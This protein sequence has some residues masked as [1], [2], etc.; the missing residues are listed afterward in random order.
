MR[1]QI[2]CIAL[3]VSLS[4]YAQDAVNFSQE[5]EFYLHGASTTIGN[6]ILGKD[7]REPFDQVD[8]S[9]DFLDMKYIDVDGYANTYSSS[10]AYLQLDA[11][12][13]IIYAVLY[14]SGTYKGE[15][16][17]KYTNK[18]RIYYKLLEERQHDV[19]DIKFKVPG[20]G[21]KNVKG[22]LIYDGQDARSRRIKSRAP[23]A[24]MADVTEYIRGQKSGYITVANV[25]ATQGEVDGGSAA[26]WLL[27]VVYKDAHEPLRYVVTHQGFTMVDKK[28]LEI[29]F[30]SFQIPKFMKFQA[31]VTVGAIDGDRS[32]EGDKASLY[33]AQKQ[34]FLSMKT[35]GRPSDNFFNSSITTF[36][37]ENKLRIPNSSNTLGFDV[38]QFSIPTASINSGAKVQYTTEADD[39]FVFF[40]AFQTDVDEQ[41]YKE[42][43]YSTQLATN[44]I[45]TN[46]NSNDMDLAKKKESLVKAGNTKSVTTRTRISSQKKVISRSNEK[47]LR[48][49]IRNPSVRIEKVPSGYYIISNVFSDVSNAE[50]WMTKLKSRG[51]NPERFYRPEKNLH[52]VFLDTGFNASEL[53][54]KVKQLRTRRGLRDTWML[55]VNLN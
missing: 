27:Y 18:D 49:I 29:D 22:T 8:M 21:Y 47:E 36:N 37:A 40:T 54:E 39:Y 23:Y 33:N 3:I 53:F 20:S 13:E 14:W 38:A 11:K 6:T 4:T 42:M 28:A 51:L 46:E 24:C 44:T 50:K 10:S 17:E 35:M 34:R 15:R 41:F 2:I 16:S 1:P 55:K 19:R 43:E 26:G 48:A 45:L 9:N 32:T 31:A 5:K 25:S 12:Q 7:A 52:Y 30:G